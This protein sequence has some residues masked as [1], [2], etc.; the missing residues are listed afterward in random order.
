MNASTRG[1][2]DRDHRIFLIKAINGR[3]LALMCLPKWEMKMRNY[4]DQ[5]WLYSILERRIIGR[6]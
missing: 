3:D 5:I 1:S 4:K 6:L 2:N